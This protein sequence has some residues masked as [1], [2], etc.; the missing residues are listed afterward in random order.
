MPTSTVVM[1]P[2]SE[3]YHRDPHGVTARVREV[4]E[5]HRIDAYGV[6]VATSHRLV[7][8]LLFDPERVTNSVTVW[9]GFEQPE[10]GSVG[11]WLL[12]SSLFAQ[13]GAEHA[14]TRRLASRAFTPAAVRRMDHLV[15][16]VV[17][18][19]A[20]A[21]LEGRTGVVDLS[22]YTLPIPATV[23]SRITGVPPK[24]GDEERF[25]A[26]VGGAVR[27]VDPF[28]DADERKRSEEQISEL[29]EYLRWLVSQRREHP[30][31][32]MVTDLVQAYDADDRFTNDEVVMMVVALVIA[33]TETTS[34]AS[35]LGLHSL[36]TNPDQLALLRSEPSLLPGAVE[37]L[38]RFELGGTMLPRFTVAECEIA[39]REVGKG[40]IVFLS[41]A[42]AHR[43]PAVFPDPDRLDVTRDTTELIAFGRGPH[44]C[45]GAH[46]ARAEMRHVVGRALEA[47]P[48][49]ATLIEEEVRFT[50][51][52]FVFRRLEN[53]PVDVGGI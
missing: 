38:L 29:V 53:L 22:E 12:T 8:Q 5:L 33:G 32:D 10:P 23:I 36:L 15:A 24:G 44:H 17:E 30:E 19:A 6:W 50:P 26:L 13:S 39:G 21:T 9:E 35:T 7:R 51:P 41:L 25:R 43:D 20:A 34:H 37:E 1:D 49:G 46:L 4:E 27:V 28:L 31:Q 18:E 16:E 2:L 52:S 45:I 47:L 42:G 11:E 14:R 3:E 40:Q 48:E